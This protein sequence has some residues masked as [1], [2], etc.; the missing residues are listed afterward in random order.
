MA[1]IR[2][3]LVSGTLTRRDRVVRQS[4]RGDPRKSARAAYVIDI[5]ELGPLQQ[6]VQRRAELLAPVCEP[7]IN[8]WGRFLIDGSDDDATQRVRIRNAD[9]DFQLSVRQSFHAE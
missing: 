5:T 7:V 2:E 8:L 1:E 6:C 9:F 4:P 3:R